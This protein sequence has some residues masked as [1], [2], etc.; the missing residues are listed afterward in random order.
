[1]SDRGEYRSFYVAF[2]DDP[3]VHT[4]SDRAYRALTM[5]KL[6][7]PPIGIGVVYPTQLAEQCGWPVKKLHAALAELETPKPG[8]RY[9]WIVREGNIV[10]VVNALRYEHT[11]AVENVKKHHPYVRKLLA[12]LGE[13][14]AIVGQFRAYYAAWFPPAPAAP[15][16]DEDKTTEDDRVSI[17]YQMPNDTLSKPLHS[18]AFHS[19]PDHEHQ[20]T[21]AAGPGLALHQGGAPDA[22][23]RRDTIAAFADGMTPEAFERAWITVSDVLVPTEKGVDPLL[24]VLKDAH[25]GPDAPWRFLM[26]LYGVLAGMGAPAPSRDQLLAALRKW[27]SKRQSLSVAEFDAFLAR[28]RLEVLTPDAPAAAR[29]GRDRPG[30]PA[31]QTY[32]YGNVVTREEDIKWQ[33]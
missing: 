2:A 31:P 24:L 27:F 30:R 9:G 22:P 23:A 28:A 11:L 10:W 18:I 14:P 33:D 26:S 8:A 13:K 17:G 12:R 29:P 3:D 7:L 15:S 25:G 4:L 16:P 21:G 32:V 5:L 20:L 1:M 6:V 19:I